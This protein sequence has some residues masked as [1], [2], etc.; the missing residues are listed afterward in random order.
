[1]AAPHALR[2]DG[3][4]RT[5]QRRTDAAPP[6]VSRLRCGCRWD[7]YADRMWQPCM[8]HEGEGH[9]AV[10]SVG[11]GPDGSA[12]VARCLVLTCDWRTEQAQEAWAVAAA[13]QHWTDTRAQH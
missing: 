3:Q 4:I 10:V 2:S 11:Q 13:Q 6:G 8:T 1:M 5:W 9:L 7:G 12:S